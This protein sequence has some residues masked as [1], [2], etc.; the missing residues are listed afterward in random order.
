MCG[1]LDPCSGKICHELPSRKPWFYGTTWQIEINALFAAL[2]R[3]HT[4]GFG[5]RDGLQERI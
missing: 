2:E 4:D 1:M 5:H 3:A